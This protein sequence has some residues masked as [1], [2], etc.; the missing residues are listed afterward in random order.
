MT[1]APRLLQRAGVFLCALVLSPPSAPAAPRVEQRDGLTIAYL[2][3]SPYE[4]GQQHGELLREAVREQISRTLQYIRSYLKIPVLRIWLGNW[5]LDRPWMVTRR[6][7]PADYLE[8]LR[9]LADGSGVPLRELWRF[10]ALP[11]RTYACANLAAWGRATADGRLI[12]TRNLDWN[13]DIGM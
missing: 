10:H 11:D 4:L 13:I 2:E 3:G 12:H 7:V 5:W 1:S 8:E 6:F 9:G